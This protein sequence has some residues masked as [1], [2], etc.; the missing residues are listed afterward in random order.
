M[1]D[2][3]C[4]DGP[5]VSSTGRKRRR[6][7]FGDDSDTAAPLQD[8]SASASMGASARHG[9][10]RGGVPYYAGLG[11][12]VEAPFAHLDPGRWPTMS[13]SLGVTP[14]HRDD[15]V[16]GMAPARGYPVAP[17]AVTQSWH[18]DVPR[19][20]MGPC[21]PLS[22]SLGVTPG[23][24]SDQG[25]T[26]GHAPA[27][28][29]RPVAHRTVT[30]RPSPSVWDFEGDGESESPATRGDG[31]GT[32]TEG[33]PSSSQAMTPTRGGCDSES[34]SLDTATPLTPLLE[35]ALAGNG[36]SAGGGGTLAGA[37]GRRGQRSILVD[38]RPPSLPPVSTG[39]GSASTRPPTYPLAAAHRSAGSR[40]SGGGTGSRHA[41]RVVPVPLQLEADAP[42]IVGVRGVAPG[43]GGSGV[44]GGA[45]VP[46]ARNMAE[47]AEWASVLAANPDVISQP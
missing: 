22:A 35:V 16:A 17:G 31:T 23:T 9:T 3:R 19:A 10:A 18:R 8:A 28:S 29:G 30:S 32:A 27:A 47:I 34:G 26:P 25:A 40:V 4:E 37:G 12:G 43:A 42:N 15:V 13:A 36:S 2:P 38:D 5:G 20:G 24:S 46:S 6:V 41:L 1:E 14:S 11:H 44:G 45:H 21:P 33:A 39:A 7:G